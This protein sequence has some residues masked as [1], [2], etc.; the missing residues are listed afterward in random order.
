M[1]TVKGAI[2]TAEK[3]IWGD[4]PRSS[5]EEPISGVKGEGTPSDPYDAGNVTGNEPI[6]GVKG[7]GTAS[8]PYDAGNVSRMH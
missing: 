2:Q 4:Q 6:S 5:G 1:E 7:Q 3:V 8:D